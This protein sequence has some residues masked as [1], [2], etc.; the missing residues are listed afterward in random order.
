MCLTEE[1]GELRAGV[2]LRWYSAQVCSSEFKLQYYKR[3]KKVR[4][5]SCKV[6]PA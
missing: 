6:I 3:Q 4:E 5:L 1:V 2:R